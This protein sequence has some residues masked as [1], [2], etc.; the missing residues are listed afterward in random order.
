MRVRKL[1]EILKVTPD[2][3]RY[4]TRI[5]F[6]SPEKNSVNGYKEYSQND[7]QHL[8][9]ILSAR[10]LGFSV[11]DI[12]Q[13]LNEA[14][15]GRTACPIV[16]RIMEQRLDETEQLFQQTLE[17]RSLMLSAIDDWQHKPNKEP[18]GHMIC[19]LIEGVGGTAVRER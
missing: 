5:G 16:R 19:D 13:I 8:R 3:V 18:T 6:L 11:S 10:Q 9:F 15:N 12:G 4:Y 7:H 17:L 14:K 1:A 2:T